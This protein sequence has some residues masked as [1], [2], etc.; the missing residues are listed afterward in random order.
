M[1]RRTV[2]LA[3]VALSIVSQGYAEE[4]ISKSGKLVTITPCAEEDLDKCCEIFVSSFLRAYED[5]TVEQ[6][7]I[8]DKT[9]FLKEAF[10]DV[11][12][13]FKV[14]EQKLFVAKSQ[15]EI[16][17]FAG[18]KETETLHQIYITQL[19]VA[20]EYSREGVGKRLLF[21]AL[22]SYDDVDS[23]VVIARKINRVAQDFYQKLGFMKSSYIH[24]GY[25]S[26]KYTGYEWTKA[27]GEC[28]IDC[29]KDKD[30]SQLQNSST[31]KNRAFEPSC[32][33]FSLRRT[34]SGVRTGLNE[35]NHT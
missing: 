12:D 18:F 27:D 13:D 26:E 16:I 10:V 11:Y 19:S 28:V 5:F 15:G 8:Q 22:S 20:P 21:S 23:L 9:L 17:G 14:G 30:E 33:P 1:F 3:L 6:L 2:F 24:P 29:N 32:D 35:I 34:W 25:S 7:G 31:R 4:F